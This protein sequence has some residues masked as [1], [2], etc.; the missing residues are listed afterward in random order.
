MVIK[1]RAGVEP[2][3]KNYMYTC[4]AIAELR[5]DPMPMVLHEAA[6][7]LGVSYEHTEHYTKHTGDQK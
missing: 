5:G 1:W 2:R 6:T 4:I 7:H 3:A